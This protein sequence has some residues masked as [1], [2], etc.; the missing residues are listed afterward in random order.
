MQKPAQSGRN[1]GCVVHPRIRGEHFGISP[2]YAGLPGSSPH[3]RGTPSSP[4]GNSQH[5]RFIPAYAGNTG[6]GVCFVVMLTV[7]PR[8]RG[9]HHAYYG[10]RRSIRGSSPHTRGTLER[11]RRAGSPGRF[12]PA[13]AGNTHILGLPAPEKTVHPRIRGEHQKMGS[14]KR[15]G[16]GSSPHTRGTPSHWR[17]RAALMRF[18]PAYAGN[19]CPR[20]AHHVPPPVHPRIR[21]EHTHSLRRRIVAGGS[22]PHTRGT[23]R[24]QRTPK[25]PSRFIPAYAG[26]TPGRTGPNVRE[27]VHPRIRGEHQG[28]AVDGAGRDGSSPHTRGTRRRAP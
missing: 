1:P 11:R 24:S 22:S 25:H 14:A 23:P 16:Y 17:L 15:A 19:T 4:G 13:Y 2:L 5:E 3:M 20:P 6:P 27:T 18:I 9:E 8:I 7:H 12:I 21:G 26:N 10:R 28:A